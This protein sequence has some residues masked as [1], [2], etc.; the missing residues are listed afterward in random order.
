MNSYKYEC[1]NIII[2][3]NNFEYEISIK[4]YEK[5][6]KTTEEKL[7]KLFTRLTS[8]LPGI[9]KTEKPEIING[10]ASRFIYF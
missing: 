2:Y 3:A 4:K 9:I 8:L 6:I 5:M 10:M 1:D 7:D